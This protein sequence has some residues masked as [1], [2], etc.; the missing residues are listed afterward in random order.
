MDTELAEWVMGLTPDEIFE[1]VVLL[2]HWEEQ[3]QQY[4]ETL[5]GRSGSD[6]RWN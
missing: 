1:R 2:E 4:L 6:V 3:L 5:K